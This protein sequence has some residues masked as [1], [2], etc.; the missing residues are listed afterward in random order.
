MDADFKSQDLVKHLNMETDW[1]GH[2]L[3]FSEII[4]HTWLSY[5][6]VTVRKRFLQNI[7]KV[8]A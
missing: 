8:T 5:F 2:T 1:T 3:N 4:Y 7:R 6:D